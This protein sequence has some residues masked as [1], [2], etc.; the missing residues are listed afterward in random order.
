MCV[1]SLRSEDLSYMTRTDNHVAQLFRG[2]GLRARSVRNIVSCVASSRRLP[3]FQWAQHAAPYGYCYGDTFGRRK[4]E[5]APALHRIAARLHLECGG[6]PPLS[7]AYRQKIKRAGPSQ[8]TQ[9]E[10]LR[11]SRDGPGATKNGPLRSGY[12]FELSL[13]AKV[14]RNSLGERGRSGRVSRV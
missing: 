7:R 10:F 9:D 12:F 13:A 11:N 14:A 4:R 8:R 1:K 6:L 2:E 3:A 5:Q